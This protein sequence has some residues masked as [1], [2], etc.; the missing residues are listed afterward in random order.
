VAYAEL[1][2]CYWVI[3]LLVLAMQM[4]PT[5]VHEV[6]RENVDW[7]ILLG[8]AALSWVNSSR[9]GLGCGKTNFDKALTL[10]YLNRI[11]TRLCRIYAGH[12]DESFGS[13][14]IANP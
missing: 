12:T 13:S 8:Y 9:M 6:Q 2:Y 7:T 1:S 5:I 10:G 3:R 11:A 4:P 14:K